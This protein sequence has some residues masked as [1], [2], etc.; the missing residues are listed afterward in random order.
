MQ[1][2]I[3]KQNK[4]THERL[5]IQIAVAHV[6]DGVKLRDRGEIVIL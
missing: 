6:V 4:V 2:I 5:E 3:K 1:R